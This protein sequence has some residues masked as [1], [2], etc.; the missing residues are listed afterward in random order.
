MFAFIPISV[1]TQLFSTARF[2]R[3]LSSLPDT[4]SHILFFIADRLQMYND[5]SNPEKDERRIYQY[6][7]ERPSRIFLER[8]NWIGR[9]AQRLGIERHKFEIVSID[10]VADGEAFQIFRG[11]SIFYTLNQ[12]FSEDVDAEAHRAVRRKSGWKDYDAARRLSAIY[13]LEE[14]ALNLRIRSR[15]KLTDEFYIGSQML[16]LPEL[17][18][19]RHSWYLKSVGLT[20]SID[21]LG[22]RFFT[23]GAEAVWTEW[24]RTAPTSS[25]S[26]IVAAE[27]R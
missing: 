19:G 25:L 10:D 2:I 11:L 22:A 13:I 18:H 17:F 21:V 7:S 26:N 9:T 3:A 15:W 20:E 6:W 4:Y 1:S 5:A 8:Q 14:L 16:I 12:A 23:W 27:T 24:P